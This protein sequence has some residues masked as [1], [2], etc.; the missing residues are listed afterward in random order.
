MQKIDY[1]SHPGPGQFKFILSTDAEKSLTVA[2]ELHRRSTKNVRFVK[3]KKIQWIDKIS[4]QIHSTL[5][6][7]SKTNFSSTSKHITMWHLFYEMCEIWQNICDIRQEPVH[8]L[9]KLMVIE[10]RYCKY[11]QIPNTKEL[12]TDVQGSDL[13]D[14]RF[15]QLC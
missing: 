12:L 15:R 11:G 10:V 6:V 14:L 1:L 9:V 4:N 13:C 7:A 2:I 3:K 5:I 8:L